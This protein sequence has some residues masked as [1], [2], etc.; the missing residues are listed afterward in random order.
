MKKWLSIALLFS[1]VTLWAADNT[2]PGG[3]LPENASTNLPAPAGGIW[4]FITADATNWFAAA[5]GIYDSD[6]Q[7]AGGGV[8]L[9]YLLDLPVVQD[10]LMPTLRFDYVQSQIWMIN[11]SMQLQL[12]RSIMGKFPVRPFAVAG[13]AVPFAGKGNEN[14]DFVGIFGAGAA[15]FITK[16][17]GVIG[18]VEY[19]EG[20]KFTSNPQFRLG[21]FYR[22]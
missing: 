11:G 7:T 5:Y 17:F 16:K 3:V 20:A 1:A 10:T 4:D 14:G 15:A 9:S 22:F 19:W 18:D 8:G 21:L 13:V 12:P 6:S 2:L